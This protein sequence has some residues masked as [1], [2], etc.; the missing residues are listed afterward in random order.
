MIN[1]SDYFL[2][3]DF[4]NDITGLIPTSSL[5]KYADFWEEQELKRINYDN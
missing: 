5:D 3:V 1:L 4:D 2:V